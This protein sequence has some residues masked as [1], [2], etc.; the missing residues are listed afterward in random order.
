MFKRPAGAAPVMG[1]P[2]C[3][4]SLHSQLSSLFL[5]LLVCTLTAH[6]HTPTPKPGWGT[7]PL[8]LSLSVL[9]T[10][11]DIGQEAHGSSN[12]AHL[13]LVAASSPISY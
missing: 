13:S 1:S 11:G 6:A 12:L 10:A 4:P 8:T 3:D 5:G 2:L 9:H 7:T